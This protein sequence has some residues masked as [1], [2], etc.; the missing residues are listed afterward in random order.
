MVQSDMM[1]VAQVALARFDGKGQVQSYATIQSTRRG[2]G[3]SLSGK[4]SIEGSCVGHA[5]LE[6]PDGIAVVRRFVIVH[7]GSEI[8]TLE[9]FP[10][11][12]SRPAYSMSFTQRKL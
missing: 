1:P 9:I 12:D 4:Y 8:E 3:L 11:T 6:S 10:V 7:G 2:G 5:D